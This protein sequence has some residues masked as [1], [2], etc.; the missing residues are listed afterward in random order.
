M[1][2]VSLIDVEIES[3]PHQKNHG[4]LSGGQIFSLMDKR[5]V[6]VPGP[7]GGTCCI[8]QGS[9]SY[10]R[11]PALPEDMTIRLQLNKQKIKTLEIPT[12]RSPIIGNGH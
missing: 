2:G 8:D 1:N 11:V 6:Y 9:G 10:A 3:T 5:D 7:P 12:D 4:F